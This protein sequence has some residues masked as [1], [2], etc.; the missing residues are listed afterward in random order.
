MLTRLKE[1]FVH[2]FDVVAE[3]LHMIGLGPMAATLLGLVAAVGSSMLYYLTQYQ[4]QL[5]PWAAILLLV[6][7][8]FDAAD[9]AIARL[10]GKV[11]Q[12][13]GFFDS[14][15]DRINELL[16]LSSIIL[17]HL[18]DLKWGLWAIAG[19]FLVSYA[20]SRGETEGVN[21]KVGVAERPERLLILVFASLLGLVESGVVIVA[22]MATLTLFQR[23]AH[24]HHQLSLG[25]LSGGK[26]RTA[27]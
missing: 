5:L 1:S 20:R 25:G 7:G 23:I 8:F 4:P 17:G 21:M 19:S 12:F 2:L 16:V 22:I 24:V 15:T 9:G 6:S 11:S 27:A 10:F 14:V 26:A 3:G 18:C 13:G